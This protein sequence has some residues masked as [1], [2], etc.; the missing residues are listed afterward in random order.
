[1][2]RRVGGVGG[3]VV[4]N[5][6]AHQSLYRRYRPRTFDEIRGQDH[7]VR[8]LR[9]AVGQGTEGHA[10]LFSGPRGTGKTS[11]ARILAKALNCENLTEGQPCA[12][13]ESCLSIEKGS[14][15]DL[16]ELDAASNNG[17]DAMRDLVGRTAVGSPG[18]T[19]VYILDEVHMLSPAASNALLKTLEEPP[20][21]VVFVLA[22]T[23]PQ[24]VLPTIRSRTQHFEFTLLSATDLEAFVRWIIEDASLE[25]DAESVA[26]VVRQGRGSARDTLSALDMV[27]AGGGVAGVGDPSAPILAAIIAGDPGAAV[28][29]LGDAIAM[30]REPRVLADGLVLTLRDAFLS[31]VGGDLRHLS[32]DDM[33]RAA[34]TASL[35]GTARLTRSLG[36]LGAA[37]VDMRQATEA[38]VPLDVALIQIC[39]TGAASLDALVERVERLE[40][41]LASGG[42]TP[43]GPSARPEAAPGDDE[44]SEAV[45]VGGP[46]HQ[47]DA[48]DSADA[49]SVDTTG[50]DDLGDLVDA[51]VSPDQPATASAAEAAAEARAAIARQRQQPSR[52]TSRAESRPAPSPA[53]PPRPPGPA[54][55]T[56]PAAPPRPPGP[57][58]PTAPAAPPRPPGPASPTAPVAAAPGTP[59]PAPAPAT[60]PAAPSSGPAVEPSSEA[61]AASPQGASA[62]GKEGADRIDPTGI[63]AAEELQAAL[64]ASVLSRLKGMSK[65]I[66]SG[67]HFVASEPDHAVFALANEPTRERAE[68]S[69]SEVEAALAEHFGR[70]V[71]LRLVA[72]SGTGRPAG[73]GASPAAPEARTGQAPADAPPAPSELPDEDETIVDVSDL[74]DA[75]VNATTGLD[76]VIEAFPGAKMIEENPQ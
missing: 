59:A 46:R 53:A 37:L 44:K 69:R 43:G 58:S 7:V 13:C 70:A 3:P 62:A 60:A 18:R 64:G 47:G 63:P 33:G 2:P 12:T 24:K 51:G 20:E 25:V 19:K 52:S 8:A 11:T 6:M 5:P 28:S 75:T 31:S 49:T 36:I 26:Q 42:A 15:Y 1:M 55:P 38:R 50:S 67:G 41:A 21:H 74:E 71:P 34:E 45:G 39:E 76:K 68:N 54:S 65:A 22:T 23:D 72:V 73:A 27:V 32:D 14:S 56:A 66:F 17:V 40:A 16:F 29:S 10:Y 30:G 61:V 9:N 57:A 4:C 35:M 48:D